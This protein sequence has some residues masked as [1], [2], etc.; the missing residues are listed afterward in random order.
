MN[1]GKKRSD[2]GLGVT[3]GRMDEESS[4]GLEAVTGYQLYVDS[5]PK[6]MRS[7]D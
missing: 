3:E 2:G 4:S 6:E 5:E 1:V 7:G